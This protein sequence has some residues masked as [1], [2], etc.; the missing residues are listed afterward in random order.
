MGFLWNRR[1]V[2]KKVLLVT[3]EDVSE[4]TL[5]KHIEEWIEPGT[6]IVSECWK[7]YLNLSKYGYIH[8]TVHRR[9][10]D[11]SPRTTR[12]TLLDNSPRPRPTYLLP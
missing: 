11:N 6:T 5:L 9:Y 8:K 12:P 2:L 10:P 4:K 1:G 7:A 3:V